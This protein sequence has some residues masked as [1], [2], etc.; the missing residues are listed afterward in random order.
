M[1]GGAFF[2]GKEGRDDFRNLLLILS[3]TDIIYNVS[4]WIHETNDDIKPLDLHAKPFC[5]SCDVIRMNT[6]NKGER[7][8]TGCFPLFV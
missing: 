3:E 1:R 5:Q 6:T 4:N 2:N 8:K 7:P